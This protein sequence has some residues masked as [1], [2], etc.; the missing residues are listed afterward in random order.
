MSPVLNE[1]ARRVWAATEAMALGHG[2]VS[3]VSRAT[4]LSRPTIRAGMGEIDRGVSVESPNDNETPPIR[5]RGGGRKSNASKDP[6]LM[7][8]LETL[9]ESTTRGDPMSPLKWTCKSLRVLAVE[10]AAQGH[11][12]S[13]PVVGD[14]LREAEYSL[15]GAQKVREGHQHEDRNAQF[16]HISARVKDFQQRGQPVI[17]VDT[18][19]KE[20]VGDFKN[21][22]REWHPE[23][24]PPQV[25]VH[26][27][28]DKKLGKAIPYGVYDITENKSWVSVGI[29]HD[30]SEFA[31]ATIRRWWSE[32]GAERYPDARELLVTADGGGSNGSRT[33]LWKSE[34]QRF[35]NET[36]LRISVSHLPPGT[37][38][39]NKIEHRLFCHITKNWRGRPLESLEVVVNLIANTTTRKGL[40]VRAALDTGKY[41]KGIRVTKAEME[42]LQIERDTFHGEWNYT[43]APKGEVGSRPIS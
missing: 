22:G 17:S 5:R 42:A 39:W 11:E 13:H 20:N 37:S 12:V 38:K 9:V 43:I 2:G 15:Q 25:R 6:T 8:D 41:A 26:D 1:R 21:A 10:L 28:I 7:R 16:E 27:F 31:V 29:D 18:K 24:K 14:L 40:R 4:G 34:L 3:I 35:A 32:M 33:R 19:K 23:G 36:G 30:T